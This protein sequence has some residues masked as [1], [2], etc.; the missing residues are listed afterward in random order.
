LPFLFTKQGRFSTHIKSIDELNKIMWYRIFF[1][2]KDNA[3]AP[4]M[5][6]NYSINFPQ[7]DK[8]AAVLLSI[9]W[10]SFISRGRDPS[11]LGY[12][13]NT[14]RVTSSC[15]MIWIGSTEHLMSCSF[16]GTLLTCL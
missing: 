12:F 4:E 15:I 8:P 9:I 10:N 3:A 7:L 1:A 2:P 16:T 6:W 5:L 11:I 14:I 13:Y